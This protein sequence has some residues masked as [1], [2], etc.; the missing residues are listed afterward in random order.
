MMGLEGLE[1][2][3]N[4]EYIAVCHYTKMTHTWPPQLPACDSRVLKT[5]VG[6]T[7]C[8]PFSS[9]EDLNTAIRL[10]VTTSQ[11]DCSFLTRMMGI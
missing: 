11:S 4:K 9:V 6:V 2:K 1:I 10:T 8:A 7:H 5:P 3:L